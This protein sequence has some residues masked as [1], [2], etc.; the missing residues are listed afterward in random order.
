MSIDPIGSHGIRHINTSKGGNNSVNSNDVNIPSYIYMPS[1]TTWYVLFEIGFPSIHLDLA[2]AA[3]IS[4]NFI[5]V[6]NGETNTLGS[7]L[8]S[9]N[10]LLRFKIGEQ[11]PSPLDERRNVLLGI[12]IRSDKKNPVNIDVNITD[13]LS[14]FRFDNQNVKTGIK[15]PLTIPSVNQVVINLLGE[16]DIGW[17]K[18]A[19]WSGVKGDHAGQFNIILLVIEIIFLLIGLYILG[20]KLFDLLRDNG[21][22]LGTSFASFIGNKSFQEKVLSELLLLTG[23][24]TSANLGLAVANNALTTALN[25]IGV[26]STT[27]SQELSDINTKL[28]LTDADKLL[29]QRL[30]LIT[31]I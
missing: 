29:I 8:D 11:I 4:Y 24:V 27:L 16:T 17:I 19:D 14:N 15:N 6:I 30:L 7:P 21:I 18:S 22:N 5:R 10:K 28:I 1:L 20:P 12:Y 23:G 13:P 2:T 3:V 9:L 26:P 31:T 25:R